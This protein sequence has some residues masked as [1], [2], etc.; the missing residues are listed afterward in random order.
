[1]IYKILLRTCGIPLLFYPPLVRIDISVRRDHK[2]ENAITH[3]QVRR[4]SGWIGHPF[5]YDIIAFSRNIV[6][7]ILLRA[8][9]LAWWFYVSG[10]LVMCTTV[11]ALAWQ[12][13][14]QTNKKQSNKH[15]NEQI[16]KCTNKPL[17][18]YIYIIHYLSLLELLCWS[19]SL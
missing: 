2:N 19:V 6:N 1:M 12:T 7:S 14:K 4:P 9:L 5:R 3:S 18:I 8:C 13:N 16:N 15:T 10:W 11:C 17:Y